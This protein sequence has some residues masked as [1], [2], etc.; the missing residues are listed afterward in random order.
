MKKL[1]IK[2]KKVAKLKPAPIFD[3][4]PDRLKTVEAYHRIEKKLFEIVQ[5]DHK[6]TSVKEYVTCAWCNEKRQMRT[7]AIKSEGFLSLEQYLEWKKIM[8]IISNKRN[9]QL[10]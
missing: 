6:H 7:N 4:L 8:D 3:G 1:N 2:T 10:K 9:I 5:T